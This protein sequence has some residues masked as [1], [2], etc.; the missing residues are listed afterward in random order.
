MRRYPRHAVDMPI[1]LYPVAGQ[2][3]LQLRN[4]SFG[5][6]RCVSPCLLPV[7]TLVE[8]EIP[9]IHPPTYYGQGM[10]MWCKAEGELFELGVRFLSAQEQFESC[11]AE[12]IHHIDVYRRRVCELEGRELS[13]EQAAGEWISEYAQRFPRRSLF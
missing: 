8:I 5:G 3:Q 7:G 1:R 11:M 4:Y 12:Q 6:L 13:V 10:V 2:P 9:D